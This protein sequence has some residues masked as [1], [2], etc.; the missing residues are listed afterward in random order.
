MSN[1]ES[2]TTSVDALTRYFVG[3]ATMGD[4]LTR[5]AELT[6]EA[7][8]PAVYVGITLLIEDRIGTY[9][10]THPE[11]PEIDRAQY[12]T[13]DGPCVDAYRTGEVMVIASTLATDRWTEFARCAAAHG[14]R[15]TL[16]LPL[17]AG[18]STIGALNLYA[19]VEQ[20]FGPADT[21]AAQ[22]F[23]GQAAFLLANAQAYWDARMLNEGLE[24]AMVHRATIE[25]AKGLIMA[26]TRCDPDQAFRRLVAQSQ[27]ENVKV[28]DLAARLVA[29]AQGLRH[30]R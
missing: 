19:E 29:H 9:V 27:H 5:V 10:F 6:T 2:I 26:A 18:S 25:Q 11:V 14:V 28:R 8:P 21:E 13:G 20:A 3:D 30:E 4:T 12:D 7:V 23:A 16:S 1:L 24:A 15:S 22:R 17:I